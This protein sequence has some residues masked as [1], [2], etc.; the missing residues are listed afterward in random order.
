LEVER[1][2]DQ[3]S[4]IRIDSEWEAQQEPVFGGDPASDKRARFRLPLV[5]KKGIDLRQIAAPTLWVRA[6][7]LERAR[8]AIRDWPQQQIE[9]ELDEYRGLETDLLDGR[10]ITR[11]TAANVTQA[12]ALLKIPARFEIVLLL[13][14]ETAAWLRQRTDLS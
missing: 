2:Q 12:E 6:P 10:T 7:D 9:L 8:Q 11:V 3:F 5:E 4:I 1:T 14:K 13:S